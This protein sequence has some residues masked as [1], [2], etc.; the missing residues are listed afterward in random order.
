MVLQYYEESDEKKAAFGNNLSEK[1]WEDIA[2]I[3]DMYGDV[4]FTAPLVAANVAHEKDEAGNLVIDES[5]ACVVRRIFREFLSGT[6]P[7]DIAKGLNRDGV[8]GVHGRPCWA[9]VT[10]ERM[11]RNEKYVGDLL[12]QKT[13]TKDFIGKVQIKNSGEVEQYYIRDNHLAIIC[14]EDWDRVQ[15]MLDKLM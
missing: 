13:Y 11:L 6:S 5:Q 12:M 14:R 9:R 4:L 8:C 1:Q 10:I 2:E 15:K 3:K 7:L